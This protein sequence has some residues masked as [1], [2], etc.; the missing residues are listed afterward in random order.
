MKEAIG[1]NQAFLDKV[2]EFQDRTS[3]FPLS[4]ADFLSGGPSRTTARQ[5]DK[6]N[7]TLHQM[8]RDWSVEGAQEREQSYGAVLRELERLLPVDDHKTGAFEVLVPGA[9]LGR[10]AMEIVSRGYSTQG[11]PHDDVR[12]LETLCNCCFNNPVS[13]TDIKV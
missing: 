6:V 5:V 9:G 11:N 1:R 13:P 12:V 2:V 8:M 10:L 4:E 7:T 3:P